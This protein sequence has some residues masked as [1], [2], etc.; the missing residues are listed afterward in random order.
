MQFAKKLLCS[1]LIAVTIRF[2]GLILY[3]ISPS[4]LYLFLPSVLFSS[5]AYQ[6]AQ[7]EKRVSEAR[8]QKALT[9]SDARLREQIFAL[10]S[11]CCNLYFIRII[12]IFRVRIDIHDD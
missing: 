5:S 2:L 9:A 6:V 3:F 7:A 12:F 4:F 10:V 8:L 11:W 1:I